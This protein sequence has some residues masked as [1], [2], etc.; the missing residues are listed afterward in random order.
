MKFGPGFDLFGL[1]HI[2][3]AAQAIVEWGRVL[4]TLRPTRDRRVA[5]ASRLW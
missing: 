2:Q 3:K 5:A 1:T 4:E